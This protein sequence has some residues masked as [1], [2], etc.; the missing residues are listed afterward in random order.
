MIATRPP[1]LVTDADG[2][3]VRDA[4]SAL[5]THEEHTIMVR[6]RGGALLLTA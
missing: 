1:R 2:W 4:R 5:S 6:R 3:T